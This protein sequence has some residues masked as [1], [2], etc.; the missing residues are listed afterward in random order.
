MVNL[1]EY[2]HP[3]MDILFLAL[4]APEKSNANKHWF[5]GNLSF[6]NLLFRSEL[7]SKQ[8]YDPLIGDEI[9]FGSNEINY[10]HWIYGVTDLNRRDV[11]TDSSNVDVFKQDVL[12][13]INIL[14]I[15][16]V[17]RL[18]L[19]HSK[20]SKAFRNLNSNIK[21]NSNRY[22]LVG[23]YDDIQIFE[24]PFHNASVSNKEIYYKMLKN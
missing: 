8:I 3:E 9:V 20:V 19:M 23:K 16:N 5:S 12:R 4:N 15:H 17:K 7:I 14:N 21:F 2:I 6:W 11:E 10:M 13:I 18:C 22:G 1:T 24:V